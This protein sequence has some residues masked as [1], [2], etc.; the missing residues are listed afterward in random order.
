MPVS[1]AAEKKAEIMKTQEEHKVVREKKIAKNQ[2]DITAMFRRQKCA[3]R[4]DKEVKADKEALKKQ[5]QQC[6]EA[7]GQNTQSS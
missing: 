5:K 4:S 1:A 7:V 3:Q 6:K 2:E